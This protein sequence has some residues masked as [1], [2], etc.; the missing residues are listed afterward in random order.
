M[1]VLPVII[2]GGAGQRLWPVSLPQH[3]KPFV[4]LLP[5]GTNLFHRTLHRASLLESNLAPLVVCNQAHAALVSKCADSIP[6]SILLEPQARDTAPAICAAMLLAQHLHGDDVLLV[7]MPADHFVEDTAGFA[8]TIEQAC[9]VAIGNGIVTIAVPPLRAATEYGYLRLAEQTFNAGF[10]EVQAFI[11]KPEASMANHLLQGPNFWNAGIFVT[12]AAVLL[13]AYKDHAPDILQCCAQAMGQGDVCQLETLAF[14]AARKISFDY[15]IMEKYPAVRAVKASFDW[16][17]LGNWAA[18]HAISPQD[19][20]GNSEI[21][22]VHCEDSTA[23]YL[24]SKDSRLKACHCRDLIA[25]EDN[26]SMLVMPLSMAASMRE[27]ASGRAIILASGEQ[28][29]LQLPWCGGTLYV[30]N[31]GRNSLN[32]SVHNP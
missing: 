16:Q 29:Q 5:D 13:Q 18:I 7:V 12:Q 1:K 2:A 25:V 4:P 30:E 32:L 6:V 28:L 10:H 19:E 31:C 8:V 20:N 15:A 14:A 27:P 17:D 21:G 11:E 23:V 26:G 24:R 3:P 9:S 22:E